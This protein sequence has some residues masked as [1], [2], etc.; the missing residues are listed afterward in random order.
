LRLLNKKIH[1]VYLLSHKERL[2]CI[3]IVYWLVLIKLALCLLPYQKV[4][5]N[6]DRWA[7]SFTTLKSRAVCSAETICSLTDK[8]ANS[9]PLRLLCLP[10]AFTGYVQ[11]RRNGYKVELKI[12]I[13]RSSDEGF[14]AHAWI[15]LN[16]I[17]LIGNR[18]DICEFSRFNLEKVL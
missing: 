18:P 12:G 2:Q 17:I 5:H 15:E 14:V 9:I 13:R 11:C 4:V 6:V 3:S 8:C 1:A 16:G 7:N 10:R